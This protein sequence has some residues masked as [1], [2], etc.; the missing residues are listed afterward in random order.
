MGLNMVSYGELDVIGY[1]GLL[2]LFTLL[3]FIF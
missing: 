1:L 3:H 2:Y